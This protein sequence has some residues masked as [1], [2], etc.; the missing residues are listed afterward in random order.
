MKTANFTAI[1]IA[2][3]CICVTNNVLKHCWLSIYSVDELKEVETNLM[4]TMAP[5]GV[6]P[7]VPF[8]NLPMV[9][10]PLP[11]VQMVLPMVPLVK[12]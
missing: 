6:L 5:F 10:L 8:V 2:V 9:P 4:L 3:S 7:M 12:P 1:K 11:L